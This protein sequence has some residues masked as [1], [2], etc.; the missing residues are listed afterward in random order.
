MHVTLL[1]RWWLSLLSNKYLRRK[2]ALF[3]A[4]FN[5]KTA[6]SDAVFLLRDAIQ[7]HDDP[8]R[9]LQV[10]VKKLKRKREGNP[11]RGGVK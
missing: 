6:S 1:R 11:R 10:L 3:W 5:K 2:T 4:K 8:D 9:G 7:H